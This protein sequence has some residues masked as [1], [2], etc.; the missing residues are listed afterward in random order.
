M[1]RIGAKKI[2]TSANGPG[3]RFVIWCQGCNFHCE[4]CIN[5][6]FQD[7]D[8]GSLVSI[9]ELF[10][11]IWSMKDSID[12]VTFSG[13][14]PFLQA[15]ALS[16]LAERVQSLGLTVV[17]YTGFLFERLTEGAVPGARS[18]LANCDLLIDGLFEKEKRAPLKWRGSSNQ[19]LIF[20]SDRL[21]EEDGAKSIVE[22]QV[23]NR[24]LSATG[25]FSQE[26]L[27]LF[28]KNLKQLTEG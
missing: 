7:P 3:R 28:E 10:E 27:S 16:V 23:G 14:E 2:S 5:E 12:G 17:C 20:L 8:G 1:L 26:F 22:F 4:G 11:E 24:E 13:G 21:K 9:D 6:S 15:A 18:L 19:R 25:I